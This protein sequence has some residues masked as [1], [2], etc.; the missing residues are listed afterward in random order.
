MTSDM[1]VKIICYFGLSVHDL[2]I[3]KQHVTVCV[4]ARS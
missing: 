2:L 4:S 3:G 1:L